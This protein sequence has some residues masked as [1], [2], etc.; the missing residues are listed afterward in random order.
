MKQPIFIL[1]FLSLHLARATTCD[2]DNGPA[3]VT[4]CIQISRYNNEY[5]WATCLTNAYI[6]Q[7]SSHQHQCTDR[8]RTYCWYQC[9]LEVY[10]KDSGPVSDD[11]SC[12]LSNTTAKPYAGVPTTS[13]PQECESPKGDSC[14]WYRNC[15]E[16]R[17]PCEDTSNAYAIK[18]A[19]KFC[20]LYE[21]RSSLFSPEGRKWVDAVRKC[22]QVSLVPI[23]R[24]WYKFSCEDIRQWAFDSHTP[25]YLDPDEGAP[26][27]C[28]LDCQDFFKIFWTIKGSFIQ[29][30][31]FW[32]TLKGMWNIGARCGVASQIAKCFKPVKEAYLRVQKA[33]IKI[34]KIVI[35]KLKKLLTWGK[36]S[37]S[38]P[39][40][41]ADAQ[42]RFADRVGS[43][44][45]TAMNWNA[46]VMDWLAY[47]ENTTAPADD[48][49]IM[50]IIIVLADIKALGIVNTSAPA[51]N[52]NQTIKEFALTVANGTLPLQVDGTNV[53][54]KSL[55]SCSDKSCNSS[56]VLAVSDKPPTI[57][58]TTTT[59]TIF[60]WSTRNSARIAYSNFRLYGFTATLVLF[61]DKLFF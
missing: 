4:E 5:Q 27:I 1:L 30:D 29:L 38:D 6:Q 60:K 9:M 16:K 33:V 11:C 15:L 50:N 55:A 17:Y 14:D 21:N 28:D 32:E 45:A 51:I 22:L 48:P 41:E 25:C 20:R 36:R 23:L 18:Y 13:L 47:P 53:W 2:R 43:A 26:S 7:K 46:D 57:T 8:T 59:T 42:S 44:I 3:G 37:T 31:T 24:P 54:V 56:Q 34:I 58:T 52:F 12:Q 35:K 40:P 39:L 10:E 19:E 61:V 49:D